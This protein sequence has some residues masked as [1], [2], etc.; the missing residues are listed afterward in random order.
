MRSVVA[1]LLAFAGIGLIVVGYLLSAPWGASSLSDAEPVVIGAPIFFA[2][3][4]VSILA[5]AVLYELWPTRDDE[6]PS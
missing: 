6:R 2:V 3:G 4:I 1:R 5:S